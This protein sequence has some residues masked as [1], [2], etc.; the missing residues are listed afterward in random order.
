M[1]ILASID[2]R[3]YAAEAQSP[4]DNPDLWGYTL[5][6][7]LSSAGVRVDADAVLRIAAAQACIRVLA[8]TLGQLPL[9]MFEMTSKDDRQIARLHPLY[10]V[11]H[12]QPNSWQ[13]ASEWREMMVGHAALRK[14]AY[15]RILPGPRGPVDQLIPL[16][17][18]RVTVEQLDN[19]RMVYHYI[20]RKGIRETY[21]QDEIFHIHGL[22][23]DG[24][25]GLSQLSIGRDVFGTAIATEKYGAALYKNGAQVGGIIRKKS[26]GGL[27]DT[28][29]KNI[30]KDLLRFKSGG[31]FNTMI[32]EDDLE[33]TQVG[34]RARDAEFLLSRKFSVI[35]IC[36]MFRV[37]PHLIQD[38]ERAT[39]SNI[40]HQAIEFVV[41]TLQPW[42]IRFEQA[43]RRDLLVG[44]D[45]YKYF[46][47]FNVDGLLRGDIVSRYTAYGQGITNGFLTRNEVRR[48]ENMN[49]IEGLDTPL[50]P[51]NMGNGAEPPVEDTPAASKETM[52]VKMAARRLA[53]KEVTAARKALSLKGDALTSW[54]DEFYAGYTADVSKS[55]IIPYPV[56]E[57]FCIAAKRT[58]L[59]AGDSANWLVDSWVDTRPDTLTALSLTH[60]GSHA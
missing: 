29:R 56:A 39:F 33:W 51:L 49:P 30:E 28:A 15:S 37:P 60:G 24:I 55:L 10:E 22:S 47:E 12:D 59:A 3:R 52:F 53:T 26:A 17:P 38:L 6:N 5:T 18:D 46:A 58:L 35:D 13:T 44:A 54:S 34:M 40:E 31:A 2:Q 57:E 14:G 25:C 23:D 43:I 9:Q 11:L 1:G 27:S 42:I 36:R 48:R 4:L 16:H 21:S 41:Y 20:T 50:R 45:K 19:Y 32:L 8:E 7:P